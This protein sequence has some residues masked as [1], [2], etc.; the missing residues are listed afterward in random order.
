[1]E[2][3]NRTGTR[4]SNFEL[5]RIIAMLMIVAHHFSFHGGFR[6][7]ADTVT[8][9][10]VWVQ[11]LEAGGKTGVNLFVLISGYFMVDSLRLKTGRILRLWFQLFTYSLLVY[12]IFTLCRGKSL[13]AIALIKCALPLT[14]NKWWFASAYLVLCMIA[15]FINRLLQSMDRKQY[16]EY[17]AVLTVIWCLVPTVTHQYWESNFLVWF[18]YV[19]SIAGYLRLHRIRA[20]LKASS[21]ILLSLLLILLIWLSA[22]VFD[23]LGTRWPIFAAHTDFF[24]LLQSLPVLLSAVLMF[25][26]FSKL[27]LK[28]SRFINLLAS[29]A[30]GIYLFHD[31]ELLR[32]FIWKKLFKVSAYQDSSLLIPFSL[33]VILAVFLGSMLVEL[34]RKYTLEKLADRPL[35]ALAGKLD[36]AAEKISSS[37]LFRKL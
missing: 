7:A 20:A 33:A 11:F 18:I 6:F 24:Y 28:P 5:L 31:N 1:M 36:R 26:G 32:P 16:L 13:D 2:Q 23:L 15:P 35:S 4:Q 12:V 25:T 19:Y 3:Q 27:T 17:L 34:V 10:R 29:T 30:F 8:L 9:N 21:C 22:V 14:W 37:S